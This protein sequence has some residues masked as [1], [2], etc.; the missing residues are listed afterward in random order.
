MAALRCVSCQVTAEAELLSAVVTFFES[1]RISDAMHWLGRPKMLPELIGSLPKIAIN[2]EPDQFL[3]AGR[4][5]K[6]NY[7]C[8]PSP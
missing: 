4:A 5:G 3:Q 6:V 1:A 2:A 7:S 8:H